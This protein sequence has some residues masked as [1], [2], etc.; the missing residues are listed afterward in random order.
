MLDFAVR[1]YLVEGYE[2]Q[3]R[4]LYEKVEVY[5]LQGVHRF[6]L[7][8]GILIPDVWKEGEPEEVS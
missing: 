6:V 5:D 3:I 1:L 7:D 2:G 4:K 8:G